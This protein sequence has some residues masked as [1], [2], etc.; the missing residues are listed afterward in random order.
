MQETARLCHRLG[1]V[2]IL[3]T[4]TWPGPRFCFSILSTKG[5][6]TPYMNPFDMLRC[7]INAFMNYAP[8]YYRVDILGKWVIVHKGVYF[9]TKH[10][11]R[12]HIRCRCT[13]I[14]KIEKKI[15]WTQ[16]PVVLTHGQQLDIDFL[17]V[18]NASSRLVHTSY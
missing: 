1:F 14:D 4:G 16:V 11:K 3:T 18:Y 10:V 6:S 7:E 8:F 13:F 5:A 9:T 2:S 12:V 17:K 15:S